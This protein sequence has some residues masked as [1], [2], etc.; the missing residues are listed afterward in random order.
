MQNRIVSLILLCAV[1]LFVAA[2]GP[3]ETA[4]P[5]L[6]PEASPTVAPAGQPENPVR[7]ALLPAD[8]D[9]AIEQETLLEQAILRATN[10]SVDI[11]LIDQYAEAIAALCASD[12]ETV[13]VA[14]LESLSYAAAIGQ[15]CGSPLLELAYTNSTAEIDSVGLFVLNRAI[16]STN[17]SV[18]VGRT[19]CRLS[20]DDYY[21]WLIPSIM[22]RSVGGDLSAAETVI[23]YDTVDAL[24]TAV[25]D[26]E[27]AA[28]GV[29]QAQYDNFVD[30]NED[31]AAE[32]VIADQTIPL[33][34]GVLVVPLELPIAASRSLGTGL[35]DLPDFVDIESEPAEPQSAETDETD[36][37]DEAATEEAQDTDVSEDESDEAEATDEPT[38]EPVEAPD[39]IT[40]DLTV[41]FG[42]TE[43]QSVDEAD[44][45]ALMAFL[46]ETGLDFN[47]LGN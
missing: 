2:C 11:V 15:N 21:S 32:I 7:M 5:E 38:E 18:I 14:W 26:G 9:A 3:T 24:L 46:A 33:T 35:I 12:S 45:A 22:I 1:L 44:L 6:T 28:T 10:V 37:V 25:A 4:T 17:L 19:Y 29:S 30:E 40:V 23:E 20:I 43:I 41:F 36:T 34:A 16:G 39:I 31:L 13:T 42:A 27:C 47:Q 8:R